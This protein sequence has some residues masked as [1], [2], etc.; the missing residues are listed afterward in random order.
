[1][2]L[3]VG[4]DLTNGYL[5]SNPCNDVKSDS[6]MLSFG[7][8]VHT[9]DWYEMDCIVRENIY[10]PFIWV[11]FALSIAFSICAKHEKK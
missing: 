2:F 1:M 11:S 7:N 6:L 8:Q 4:L 10:A 9:L 3:F 5:F